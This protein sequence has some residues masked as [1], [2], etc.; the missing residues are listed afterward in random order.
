VLK[1]GVEPTLESKSSFYYVSASRNSDTENGIVRNL[2]YFP[3]YFPIPNRAPYDT[4]KKVCIFNS[5]HF[6]YLGIR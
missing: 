3:P 5:T 4:E 1:Q 2:D 6:L